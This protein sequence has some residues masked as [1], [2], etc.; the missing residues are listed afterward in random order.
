MIEN[1]RKSLRA[2]VSPVKKTQGYLLDFGANTLSLRTKLT[3]DF[4]N[5]HKVLEHAIDANL[6]CSKRFIVRNN[7]IISLPQG[8][9]TFLT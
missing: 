5:K 3:E 2:I 9:L 8:F 4:L 6:N 1:I 7:K